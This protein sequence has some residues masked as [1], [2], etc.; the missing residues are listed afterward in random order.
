LSS[1]LH[2]VR[3]E[4]EVTRAQL[5]TCQQDLERTRRQLV[6]LEELIRDLPEIFERKFHQRLQP[7]LDQQQLLAHDNHTLREQARRQLPPAAPDPRS[8]PEDQ[9]G[10]GPEAQRPGSFASLRALGRRWLSRQAPP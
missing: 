6:D 9:H 5:S 1:P 4:L 8:A 7:L 10:P 2:E 3:L